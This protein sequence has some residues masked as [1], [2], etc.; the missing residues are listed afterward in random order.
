MALRAT[1]HLIQSRYN[2]GVDL[3]TKNIPVSRQML[4]LTALRRLEKLT[5][6]TISTDL[7]HFGVVKILVFIVQFFSFI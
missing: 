1:V 5:V 3:A 7:R 6:R 2:L 4:E